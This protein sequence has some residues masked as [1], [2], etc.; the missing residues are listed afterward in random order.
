MVFQ[1]M[2]LVTNWATK[3]LTCVFQFIQ[4]GEVTAACKKRGINLLTGVLSVATKNVIQGA[5]KG[6][7]GIAT[8]FLGLFGWW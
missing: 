6:A 3:V 4:G 5:A 1:D 8:G 7:A 2:L